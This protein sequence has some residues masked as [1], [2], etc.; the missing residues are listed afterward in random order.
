MTEMNRYRLRAGDWRIIY[1]VEMEANLIH[2]FAVGHQR[3]V[4]R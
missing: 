3:E 1:T 4:C 2:W